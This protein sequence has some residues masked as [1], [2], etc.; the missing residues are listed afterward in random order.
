LAIDGIDALL[1]LHPI[2]TCKIPLAETVPRGM[3]THSLEIASIFCAT[4]FALNWD[5]AILSLVSG[6]WIA[7]AVGLSPSLALRVSV[8]VAK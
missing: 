8:A 6:G 4:Y 2:C 3:S 5:G 1:H 7:D